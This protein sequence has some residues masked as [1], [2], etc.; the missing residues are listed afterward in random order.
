MAVWP[1]LPARGFG[2]RRKIK[3]KITRREERGEWHG[4]PARGVA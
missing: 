3:I 4:P 2:G 1:G